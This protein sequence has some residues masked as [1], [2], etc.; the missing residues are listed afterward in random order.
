MV[1]N[2]DKHMKTNSNITSF[3]LEM[4]IEPA[5]LKYYGDCG[6]CNWWNKALPVHEREAEKP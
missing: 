3:L 6:A 5:S 2:E 4:T 1:N